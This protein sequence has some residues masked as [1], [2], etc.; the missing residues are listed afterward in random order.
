MDVITLPETNSKNSENGGNPPGKGDSYWKPSIFTRKLFVLWG[1]KQMKSPNFQYILQVPLGKRLDLLN[2]FLL[3]VWFLGGSRQPPTHPPEKNKDEQIHPALF[4]QKDVSEGIKSSKLAIYFFYENLR[5]QK[6]AELL[7]TMYKNQRQQM[8]W[9]WHDM[10]RK[11]YCFI[12]GILSGVT[13][14]IGED[15]NDILWLG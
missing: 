7:I 10:A 6:G 8:A 2:L 12:H 4:N 11:S 14:K 1:V 15:N 9:T 13:P 3:G 5:P